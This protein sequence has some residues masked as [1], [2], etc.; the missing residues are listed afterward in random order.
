MSWLESGSAC[1]FLGSSWG[2]DPWYA[3]IAVCSRAAPGR[4]D[5]FLGVRLMRRVS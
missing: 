1:A 5:Y 2:N 4:F 3:R